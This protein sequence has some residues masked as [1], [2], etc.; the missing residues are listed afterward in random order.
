MRKIF[1]SNLF[2]IK[3]YFHRIEKE[4]NDVICQKKLFK[5]EKWLILA[6]LRYSPG[7]SLIFSLA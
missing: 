3:T 2:G 1:S 6:F 7:F 4:K 5:E